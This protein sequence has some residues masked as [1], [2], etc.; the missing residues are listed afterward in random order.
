M[1]R[2]QSRP[3]NRLGSWLCLLAIAAGTI[4]APTGPIPLG[5]TAVQ[6]QEI[7]SEV[8]QAYT[9]LNRGW[10]GD[11][12]A[13]F[14]Q[15]LRRYPNSVDAKLGLAIAYRR[16]G[17]IDDAWR[18]YNEVLAQDP[19]NQLVLKTVGLLGSYRAEWQ[20]RGI[21]VLTTL[22][23]LTPGDTEARAQRAL[24]YGYQGRFQEA[25]ADYEIVLQTN[26]TADVLLG[27]AQVYTYSGNTQQGLDL[28]NRY[29]SGGGRID[30]NAAIAYGRALR[31]TGNAAQAVQVL[32]TELRQARS[33]VNAFQLRSELAQ[34]YLANNQPL[35]ATSILD[36]LRNQPEATLPLARA[37]NEIGQASNSL[38]LRQEAAALYRQELNQ[39]LNPSV[40]LQQEVADVLSGIPG[41]QDY[42]LQLY[43]ILARRQPENTLFLV[44]QVSLEQQLGLIS[45]ADAA[46]RLQSAL[47]PLP[48]DPAQRQVIAQ[49]LIQLDPPAPALLPIYQ[50]LLQS[51]VDAAFLNFR[52]AQIYSAQGDQ[53]AAQDALARYRATPEGAQDLAPELLL[54]EIERRNGNLDASSQRYAAILS[55]P[56]ATPTVRAAARMAM[57]DLTV[58]QDRPLEALLELEQLQLEGGTTGMT[59]LERNRR[60]QQLQENF[61]RRRGFQPAWERF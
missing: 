21:D 16:Q 36:P 12:I 23:T 22:L 5:I 58:E 54:A 6:A 14:Q 46:L 2:Q 15:A 18:L 30:G 38:P 34:A 44:R 43:R 33:D 59:N 20:V 47:Q 61:L 41:E 45:S 31:S 7:P 11:A 57:I 39:D 56:Q 25:L 3:V 55:S 24:L 37:L 35:Q 8:R 49:A 10:V 4:S 52:I 29:R 9:L 13:A 26:S 40:Q 50:T 28:F 42:A 17:Q 53:A 1:K 51:G 60:I 32:E 27:A 19:N 48:S